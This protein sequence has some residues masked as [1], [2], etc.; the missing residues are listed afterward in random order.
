[1]H[2]T[3]EVFFYMQNCAA[4]LAED[5]LLGSKISNNLPSDLKSRMNEE[6]RFKIAIKRYLN[7]LILLC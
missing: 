3:L 6:A 7:T 4:I 1:M 5:H 2:E